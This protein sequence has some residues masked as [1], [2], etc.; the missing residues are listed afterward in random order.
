[1]D[2]RARTDTSYLSFLSAFSLLSLSLSLP[3][4][5]VVAA[6]PRRVTAWV[7]CLCGYK[8]ESGARLLH[9][10]CVGTAQGSSASPGRESPRMPVETGHSH[11]CRRLQF[12]THIIGR[13]CVASGSCTITSCNTVASSAHV[14]A[15]RVVVCSL[16]CVLKDTTLCM[17]MASSVE[18]VSRPG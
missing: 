6:A 15:P 18:I 12:L 5:R 17:C 14:C 11:C 1:M 8:F 3:P 4:V 7:F 10:D 9:R 16:G 2:H 13:F